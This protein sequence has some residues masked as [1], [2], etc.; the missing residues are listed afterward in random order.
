MA[1]LLNSNQVREVTPPMKASNLELDL[2]AITL[3]KSESAAGTLIPLARVA[4]SSATKNRDESVPDLPTQRTFP[5]TGASLNLT[6]N[7]T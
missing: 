5:I 7:T 6:T 2:T 4:A 3:P 1:E